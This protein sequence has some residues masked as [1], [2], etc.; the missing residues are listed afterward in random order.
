[1]PPSPAGPVHADQTDQTTLPSTDRRVHAEAGTGRPG[2][3]LSVAA[4]WEP[5]L[6]R[7]GH[8]PASE[9]VE[10]FWLPVLGPAAT[11]ALRWMARSLTEHPE[12][13]T[14]RIDDLAGQ[15]GLS[16]A[17]GRHAACPKSLDRL[18]YFDLARERSGRLEVRT[19]VPSLRPGAVRRLPPALARAHAAHPVPIRPGPGVAPPAAMRAQRPAGTT[20]PG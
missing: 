16:Q 14:V 19:H 2:P 10:R 12:G 20:G 17:T 9:Y 15:L 8:A 5:D 1:M 18:C 4:W 11:L 7:T 13:F 3:V 6:A